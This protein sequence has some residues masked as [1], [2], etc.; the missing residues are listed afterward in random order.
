VSR[1]IALDPGGST[2]F[3]QFTHREDGQ[4]EWERQTLGPDKHHLAL[5][6]L[7]TERDPDVVICES[8]E[9]RPHLPKAV[10]ISRE[11]IGVCELFNQAHPQIP[12]IMQTPAQAKH[13]WTQD[14]IEKLGLWIPS[15]PHAMDATRH[16][17]YFLT[18]NQK[19]ET[20]L[21][22]LKA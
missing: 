19:D 20:W 21:F 3:T 16:M 6:E 2:G 1:F 17:L 7:L 4:H 8:F 13:F 12:L 5:W 11:Y 18:F 14:K 10:L 15:A 22:R 9:H